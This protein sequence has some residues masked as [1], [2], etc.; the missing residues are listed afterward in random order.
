MLPPALQSLIDE[1]SKLP[2][3]GPRTAER[4]ALY[5]LRNPEAQSQALA[6]SLSELHQ[7]IK[8]CQ[9]CHN[10]SAADLCVICQDSRREA[11]TI[12]IV[13]NPFDIV[14]I[15]RT[16]SYRGLYHVLGG[17]ISPID[18]IGPEQLNIKSLFVRLK[19]NSVG[20]LIVATNSNTEGE[21]TALYIQK[22]AHEKLGDKIKVTRLASGLPIGSDLE[23]ADQITLGRAL[24]GRRPL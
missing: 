14:A 11:T 2:G 20:E 8:Y 17:A 16:A 5:I 9:I 24:E 12:C 6:G 3:I 18:G 7:N 15:E 23:Y 10:L 1:L 13:E 4:L 21:A 19:A 22:Q